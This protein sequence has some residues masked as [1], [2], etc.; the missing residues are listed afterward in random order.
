MMQSSDLNPIE[1]L[2]QDLKRIMYK[3]MST[4]LSEL[5]QCCTQ[6]WTKIS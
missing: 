1:I 6:Q 3:Q 5:K 2:R 4:N